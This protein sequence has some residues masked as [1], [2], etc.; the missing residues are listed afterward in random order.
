MKRIHMLILLVFSA[1]LLLPTAQGQDEGSLIAPIDPDSVNPE[2]NITFPPPVYV[3]RDS[4][5]IR[6]TVSMAELRNFFIEFRPL[7][8]DMMDMDEA[9]DESRNQW[10]P[11]TLPRITAVTDD[12]LGTWNT[13]TLG[14]G[15]YELRLRINT[16]AAEPEYF[17]VSPIRVENDPPSFVAVEQTV[18]VVE[19]VAE[20]QTE[21]EEVAEEP[22]P[23]PEPTEV[24]DDAPRVVALVNANVRAGDSILYTI[25]GGLHEGDSAKIKG[26][27]SYN[28]GWFY[29]ELD[30]GRSG[31]IHPN[32]VRAEGDLSNL[33]RINPPP[34][35]PTPIPAPTAVP[36]PSTGAN[37]QMR[38]V[39]IDPHPAAC[40]VGYS[41]TVTVFNSG[42]GASTGGGMIRVTDLVQGEPQRERTEIAFGPLAAGASQR[43][44]GYLTPT[45]HID[46]THNIN[47]E[48]D[49][50]NRIAET[51]END[52]LHAVPAYILGRG[53]C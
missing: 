20:E 50:G 26:L 43:V 30:N 47:L 13:V 45:V 32:I 27:S 36:A 3:V 7:A 49:Y 35:P 8:L 6:G 12:I 9:D 38:D 22:A 48:L 53:S 46:R 1:L 17:R 14:D 28:T 42:N 19:S 44:E 21:A 41:I 29:I 24:P 40:K 4:V 52:N 23:E 39:I 34:L 15:L 25:V 33:A 31:F 11:A 51:N 5:D 37:L 18:V 16:G 2:A 10:F